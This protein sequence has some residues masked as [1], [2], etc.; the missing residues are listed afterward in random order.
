MKNL[1]FSA[2]IFDSLHKVDSIARLLKRKRA[3]HLKFYRIE[4]DNLYIWLI[5]RFADAKL[6][7]LNIAED[8]DE[9]AAVINAATNIAYRQVTINEDNLVLKKSMPTQLKYVLIG[10]IAVNLVMLYVAVKTN[11]KKA[12]HTV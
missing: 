9:I 4:S 2:T 5:D 11:Y 12:S 7:L 10:S 3:D 1:I 8:H 6:T